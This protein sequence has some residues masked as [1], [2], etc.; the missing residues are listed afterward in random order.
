MDGWGEGGRKGWREGGIDGWRDGWMDGVYVLSYLYFFL[1]L[2]TTDHG[3]MVDESV[4]S[5]S[6]VI[7]FSIT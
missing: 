5:G 6:S 2:P 1:P 3:V 7:T 4:G